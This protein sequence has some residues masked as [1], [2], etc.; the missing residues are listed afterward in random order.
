MTGVVETVPAF[1]PVVQISRAAA[2]A[3]EAAPAASAQAQL[4]RAPQPSQLVAELPNGVM[5]RLE[6]AGHDTTLVTAMIET[7]GRC[8]VTARR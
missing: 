2:V 4:T 6:C 3:Y 1:V 7:L 5:L 8:D